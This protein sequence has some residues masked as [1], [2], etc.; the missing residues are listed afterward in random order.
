MLNVGAMNCKT[1]SK[2]SKIITVRNTSRFKQKDAHRGIE[3]SE[4]SI[5]DAQMALA[6]Y[7]AKQRAESDAHRKEWPSARAHQRVKCMK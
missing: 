4:T 7:E 6:E 3:P 5:E 2:P 1:K